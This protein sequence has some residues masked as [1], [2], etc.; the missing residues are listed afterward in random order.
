MQAQHPVDVVQPNSSASTDR[1]TSVER[2]STTPRPPATPSAPLAR[3]GLNTPASSAI[4]DTPSTEQR[5]PS[6]PSLMQ[7][8]PFTPISLG[9]AAHSSGKALPMDDSDDDMEVDSPTDPSPR[10]IPGPSTFATSNKRPNLEIEYPLPPE[11][12]EALNRRFHQAHMHLDLDSTS[13]EV[14]TTAHSPAMR[15]LYSPALSQQRLSSARLPWDQAHGSTCILCESYVL[16][17]Q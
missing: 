17:R 14:S 16:S 1:A 12:L 5:S 3:Y 8:F 4:Q 2:R 10:V 7:Q 13:R 9:N 6:S 11:V 15:S